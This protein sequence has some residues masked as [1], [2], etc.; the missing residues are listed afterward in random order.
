MTGS[1]DDY[2]LVLNAGSSSLKFCVYC[3]PAGLEW[4]L[5]ARGQIDGIGT[6]P[7]L[8]AKDEGGASMADEKLDRCFQ[9]METDDPRLFEQWSRQ[10]QDIGSFEFFPVLTSAEAAARVQVEWGGGPGPAGGGD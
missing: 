5:E 6:A 3:R 10:W 1:V 8:T 9:L 7:R 2:S 4:R